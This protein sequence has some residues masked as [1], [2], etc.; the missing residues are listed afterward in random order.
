[1]SGNS[2]KRPAEGEQVRV[3]AV[4]FLLIA[5]LLSGCL[6]GDEVPAPATSSTT[7]SSR[8]VPS[9][10]TAP[11]RVA[12]LT[13]D[14]ANGT[15]PL[16]VNFTLNATGNA[17]SWALAFGDGATS[18]GTA[19][20]A[21]VNHTYAIGGNFSANLTVNYPGGQ[22]VSAAVKLTILVPAGRPAPDVLVFEFA[23][24]LGCVGDLGVEACISFNAGPDFPISGID[25]YWQA[26]DE[27]YWGLSFT[28]TVDNPLGDSDCSFT[29]ADHAVIGEANNGGSPCTGAVPDGTAFIFLYPYA[30]PALGQTLTFTV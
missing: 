25:G 14:L 9:N 6:T 22:N 2:F 23:D 16:L 15:A 18:N 26:L 11:V 3:V 10:T 19:F 17:S 13:A 29:D 27:R 20:P 5:L 4:A 1:M 8:T 12:N 7:T 24:S 28:T 30:A 21:T